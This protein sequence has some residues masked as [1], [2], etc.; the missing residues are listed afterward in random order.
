MDWPNI[1]ERAAWTAIQG[2]LAAVPVAQLTASITGGDLAGL[3]QLGLA[4]L[5]GG[6]AALLSFVKTV[7]QERLGALE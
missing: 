5:G 6:V 1:L 7:A 4:A 2:A 3:E